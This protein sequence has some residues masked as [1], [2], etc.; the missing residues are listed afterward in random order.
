LNFACPSPV[1]VRVMAATFALLQGQPPSHQVFAPASPS[2]RQRSTATSGSGRSAVG[3]SNWA[4]AVSGASAALAA[5]AIQ[6]RKQ[7]QSSSSR[8]G[9]KHCVA[10]RGTFAQ[11]VKQRH[12]KSSKA[13][14]RALEQVQQLVSELSAGADP[15]ALAAAL[16]SSGLLDVFGPPQPALAAETLTANAASADL[17]PL[18]AAWQAIAEFF[19]NP[20]LQWDENGNMLLDPQGD[21]LPDNLWTQFVA[22]QATLMQRLTEGLISL[23]VPQPFGWAVVCYTLGVRAILFPFVKSQMET[24]AKMQVLN[25]RVKELKEKYKDDENRL[26]QEVGMLF[27][28]LQVDPLQAIVPLLLQLPV[29]WGLYRGIRRLAIVEY[30]PLREGFLW[31][32]SLYGPGF[33]PDPSLDWIT[34]W[35]GPL[36][37]LQPKIGWETFGLYAL[38][39]AAIF[40]AYKQVLGAATQDKE[41][42]PKILEFFPFMLGFITVELPQAMG[43][44]IGTNIASSVALTNYT[45]ANLAAKIPGYDEFVETGK[46]P[47]GVDPEKVLAKAFGV[48][49]LTSDGTDMDDPKTVPE[50]I[51]LGRADA[52]KALVANEGRNIDEYDEK[53]IQATAYSVALDNPELME[54]LFE[55]GADP[56]KTDKQGNNLLHYSAGYGRTKFLELLFE[57]G[58]DKVKNVPNKQGQTA[59]DVARANLQQDKVADACREI[60]PLLEERGAEGKA[61]TKDDEAK[62]EQIREDRKKEEELQAAR[63]A[64]MALAKGAQAKAQ[65]EVA[66]K[67]AAEPKKEEEPSVLQGLPMNIGGQA[68]EE[69]KKQAEEIMQARGIVEEKVAE[70]LDRI[71][72]WDKEAL[73]EKFGDKFSEEQLD[74]LAEKVQQMSTEQLMQFAAT[75]EQ[76]KEEEE[77]DEAKEGEGSSEHAEGEHTEEKTKVHAK[78]EEDKV[79]AKE[80]EEDR[81]VK[82]PMK[83][84]N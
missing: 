54:R 59:L 40:V 6:T 37:E 70:S 39:P 68:P 12:T 53:G 3:T 42:A 66:A 72:Q 43:L 84:V 75:G 17:S 30:E 44:Y 60:I 9:G 31:I 25:P 38:L 52:V 21:P 64:L 74:R 22:C 62:M 35:Q 47:P 46:W 32:P 36:I 69:K 79:H 4:C 41:D 13:S 14:R 7:A 10:S 78:Q 83:F 80:E 29:F 24:T 5:V 65:A 73:R 81:M 45:K 67:A 1:P 55:L 34:Q 16:Q 2:V 49:R 57:K 82:K 28:D 61:T 76:K 51:F 56:C 33:S 11:G 26:N 19:F 50:A 48:Q 18:D 58:I 23:G 71:K 15:T 77:K 27:M 8:R 63:G 20:R